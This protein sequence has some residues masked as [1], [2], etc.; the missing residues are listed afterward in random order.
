MDFGGKDNRKLIEALAQ[1]SF[2]RDFERSFSE[3]TGLQVAL[4]P[5]QSCHLTFSGHRKENG[6]CALLSSSSRA[7]AA[8]LEI[9]EK[10]GASATLAAKTVTCSAGLCETAVPVRVGNQLIGFLRTG[11][12]FQHAPSP[13]WSHRLKRLVK[14]WGLSVDKNVLRAAYLN[15]PVLAQKQYNAVVHLLNLFAQYLGIL[16]NQL[17]LRRADT[18][19]EPPVIARARAF[20][21]EH[22]TEQLSLRQVAAA[23]SISH[24]YFCK[25]FKQGTGLTFTA[26]VARHRIEKAKGL[27]LNSNYRVSE[28]AFAV[29]FQSLTHFNRK[30]SHYTG[31]SPTNYRLRIQRSLAVGQATAAR[32]GTSRAGAFG[33]T[34]GT[35]RPHVIG[36]DV[37]EAQ[38]NRKTPDK[39]V[40]PRPA[41]PAG[42]GSD[43]FLPPNLAQSGAAKRAA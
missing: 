16:S 31:E 4:V 2:Y 40:L 28:I 20:I 25:V 22:L 35:A 21:E 5:A 17:L 33:G 34:P 8:C 29:G 18:N 26:F 43:W 6:F 30:F 7:C 38:I 9:Q 37:Q 1:S 42:L 14:R 19:T 27:L 10:L 12:I 3:V 15:T 41:S 36:R 13:K 11:Q 39:F 32:T 23:A 24:F